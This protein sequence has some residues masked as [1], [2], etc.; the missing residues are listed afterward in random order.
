VNGRIFNIQRFSIHDGPGIRTTVFLQGCPLRCAWCH[1]PEGISPDPV[2]SFDPSKCIGCG[3]CVQVCPHGAHTMD[4]EKGH[5]LERDLCQVC[6]RCAEECFAGALE[7]MGR[8]VTVA[9]AMAEALRDRTFYEV[10]G[11]GLT[12]SGGEPLMQIDFTEALLKRAKQEGLHS[13]LDTCGHCDFARFERALPYVDLFLYDIKELDSDRHREFTG[14]S[15]DLILSNLKELDRRGAKILIRL[16]IIPSFNDRDAHFEAVAELSRS[17]SNLVG[18]TILPYHPL[19]TAKAERLGMMTSARR[20]FAPPD[21]ETVD[22]WIARLREL[23]VNVLNRAPESHSP[24]PDA[25]GRS[26][27]TYEQRL[28]ALRATKVAHTREKQ[29]ELGVMDHDD[30]AIILP[31]PEHRGE[32]REGRSSSD[33]IVRDIP[34]KGFE[35]KSN[36][37]GGGFFGPK[38]CGENYR[39]LLEAHPLYIDPMSSLAGAYMVNFGATR[40]PSWN[41]DFDYSHLKERHEKYQLLSGIGASQHFCQ[42][43]SIGL[44][45][46]WGGL[47][48]KIAHYRELNS[49]DASEFYDGLEAVVLGAQNWIKRHA[50]EAARMAQAE[51]DPVLAENLRTMAEINR[52]LVTEPPQTFREAC[53]WMAWYLMIARMYNGSGALGRLDALLEPYYERDKAKGILTD[54]EAVFHLACLLLRDTSYLQLGGLDSAGQ[55]V[56]NPVS[57]LALEAAHRLQAPTNIGV[58]VGKGINPD[59]LRRGV[60]MLLEDKLGAPKFLGMDNVVAGLERSGFPVGLARERAYSGCHWFGVPGREYTLMDCVKINMA[61][62]FSVALSEMMEDSGAAPSTQRLWELFVERLRAAVGV[63]AQSLDFHLM[64]MHEVFPELVLDLCCYGPIEKGLDASHGGVEYYNMGLDGAGLA[65]VA[66][67]FA[68]VE[69]RVERE[70]RLTWTRLMEHL[71]SDWSGPGGEQA[72]LMMK[73]V[74]RYGAGGSRADE[75]AARIARTFTALVTE[76]PTPDGYRMIPGLFSWASTIDMGKKLGATPNG[77]RAGAPVSHGVNPD[78]GFRKDGAPTA[79]A[80]AVSSVQCGLGNTC[81]MQIELDPGL[82]GND[83]G[84]RIVESLIKAH[85][86]MGGTMINM[87]VM[88]KQKL[89]DAQEDPDKYPDLIVRVTGFSAYFSSLSEDFRRIVVDRVLCAAG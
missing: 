3:R 73:S 80:A 15:N 20:T 16:P 77:R 11:G 79:L 87:N 86:E 54:E 38:A 14:V 48:D 27:S 31:P 63:I 19:G 59:L 89:L 52:R 42:D 53:Q 65:T 4:P 33:Q 34:L 5:A 6:G 55:D 85:F 13:C 8:N 78:P 45:A 56:T 70:G 1:N 43:L 9:E 32:A 68:A 69:Q 35:P 66:D 22:G 71:E 51:D 60:K 18:V 57:F 36:H 72:R 2:L 84:A 24:R 64:H 67:S 61:R 37:P 49:P 25:G 46:G 62:V 29:R 50:E 74:P 75:Y 81:P 83:E 17:M 26:V 21:K 30:W 58:C 10:S 40:H 88:D 76:K 28:D 7:L 39:A 12:V 82:Y 47:L 23:G 41:P 44:E